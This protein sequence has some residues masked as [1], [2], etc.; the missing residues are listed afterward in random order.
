MKMN[1]SNFSILIYT[2]HK[3]LRTSNNSIN[4]QKDNTKDK[5]AAYLLSAVSK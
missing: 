2:H 3:G 4:T 5:P 1:S